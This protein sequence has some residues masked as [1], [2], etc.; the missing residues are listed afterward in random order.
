MTRL[1]KLADLLSS[2]KFVLLTFLWGFLL[3]WILIILKLCAINYQ[4]TKYTA[5]KIKRIQKLG[6]Q[7]LLEIKAKRNFK[8]D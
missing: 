7:V 4:G 6:K 2:M 8:Q 1:S 5:N 3:F